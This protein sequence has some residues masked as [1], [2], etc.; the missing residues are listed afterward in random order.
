MNRPLKLFALAALLAASACRDK[1]VVIKEPA[2]PTAPGSTSGK[3]T[4]IATGETPPDAEPD[5][6]IKAPAE[7][8]DFARTIEK[9]VGSQ[10]P[11]ST[12]SFS[13]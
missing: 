9:V 8:Q 7:G 5:W 3:D 6:G 2:A 13:E 10:P 4:A 1:V 12:A 11:S